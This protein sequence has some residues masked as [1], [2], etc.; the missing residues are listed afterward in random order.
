MPSTSMLCSTGTRRPPEGRGLGSMTP[1]MVCMAG[2]PL[3]RGP[4]FLYWGAR[5]W[6]TLAYEISRSFH[7]DGPGPV[8]PVL[9][10][11]VIWQH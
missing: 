8:R 10:L 1:V 2:S 5:R 9:V 7:Y 3:L 11:L 4:A 6:E